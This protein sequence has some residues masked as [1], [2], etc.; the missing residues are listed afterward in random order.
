VLEL[1][2]RPKDASTDTIEITGVSRPGEKDAERL[3]IAAI[4]K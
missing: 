2:E 4:K 3:S 1:A